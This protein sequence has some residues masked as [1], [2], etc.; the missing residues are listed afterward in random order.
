MWGVRE[1]EVGSVGVGEWEVGS[2]GSER[3]GGGEEDK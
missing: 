2:V 1:W 3:V